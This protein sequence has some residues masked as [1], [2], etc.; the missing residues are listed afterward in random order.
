MFFFLILSLQSQ[1]VQTPA[2]PASTFDP[3]QGLQPPTE[4][5]APF[6]PAAVPSGKPCFIFCFE[7]SVRRT[8]EKKTQQERELRKEIKEDGEVKGR[9]E[10]QAEQEI[11]RERRDRIEM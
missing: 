10:E 3:L 4:L 11:N 6:N 9:G 8:E 2:S 1:P 7:T 5:F